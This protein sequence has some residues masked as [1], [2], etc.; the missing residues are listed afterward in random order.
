M[1]QKGQ[2]R[3]REEGE[4]VS[5]GHN[6]RGHRREK[7]VKLADLGEVTSV[8]VVLALVASQVKP[9]IVELAQ[10]LQSKTNFLDFILAGH[11]STMLFGDVIFEYVIEERQNGEVRF[12]MVLHSENPKLPIGFRMASSVVGG[13]A[14][15]GVD[16][17]FSRGD[18]LSLDEE[19]KKTAMVNIFLDA[20]RG[21]GGHGAVMEAIE[22]KQHEAELQA[23]F[24]ERAYKIGQDIANGT[25]LGNPMK[26][27]NAEEAHTFGFV[28]GNKPVV[29]RSG[30]RSIVKG[31]DVL[32]HCVWLLSDPLR[33]GQDYSEGTFVQT[34]QL[35]DEGH[36]RSSATALAAVIRSLFSEEQVDEAKSL[37][38]KM[39][40]AKKVEVAEVTNPSVTVAVPMGKLSLAASASGTIQ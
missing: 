6:K 5:G 26:M 17:Y 9:T 22:A 39:P 23:E 29:L 13:L 1:N 27:F 12:F 36:S 31:R 35:F 3:I 11:G 4:E 20:I 32:V 28:I 19:N 15:E 10:E 40:G 25:L 30:V 21:S 8:G 18:V 14:S 24:Q 33:S 37:A 2:K 7:P 16:R 38:A 34:W